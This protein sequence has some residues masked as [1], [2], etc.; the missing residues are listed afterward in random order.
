M[1]ATDIPLEIGQR[2]GAKFVRR[3]AGNDLINKLDLTDVVA[4]LVSQ[5]AVL[6]EF[7]SAVSSVL[8]GFAEELDL[9]KQEV[10]EFEERMKSFLR[11]VKEAKSAT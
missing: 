11:D 9:D 5:P 7:E 6:A 10:L 2:L 1:K 8:P 4:L 3:Y